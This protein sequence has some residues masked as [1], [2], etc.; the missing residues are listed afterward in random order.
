MRVPN[1]ILC[2]AIAGISP[3]IAQE[4]EHSP[5]AGHEKSEIPSLSP[6]ELSDLRAG[7]GMGLA[8][9][10]ELNRYPGPK[11]VLELAD[12]LGLSFAQ[13][14]EVSTIREAMHERAVEL[15]ERIIEAERLLGMR[16]RHGHV[17]SVEV[18]EA[19]ANI[20]RLQGELRYVHLVA[21]L[22]TRWV[23]DAS[24]IEAYDRLR[25]YE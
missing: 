6:K 12:S 18:R 11:H 3:V 17:D 25:G 4:H 5:Y 16:F 23:L 22:E 24:Q 2:L 19:T 7:A 13:E 8:R 1:L 21:H 9:S 20:G 14:R 10:A 15:G